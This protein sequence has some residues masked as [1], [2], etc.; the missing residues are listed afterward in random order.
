MRVRVHGLPA[1]AA[2]LCTVTA[3]VLTVLVFVAA[4]VLA[5]APGPVLQIHSFATPTSFMVADNT[6]CL[7]FKQIGLTERE[8][9]AYEVTVTNVGSQPTD[10]STVA[11]TDVLPAGVTVQRVWFD[12]SGLPREYGPEGTNL[13][14]FGLCPSTSSPVRCELPTG[15]FGLP[16]VAPDDTLRMFVYVTVEP[17]A[18]ASLTNTASVSGGGAGEAS[19]KV[20][21]SN[22]TTTPSFGI[23]A[24]ESPI[25]GLDGTPATQ[26]GAH[27]YEFAQRIDLNNVSRITP[28]SVYP[29]FTSIHDVRDVAVDLPVGFAGSALATPT[30]TLAQ[31][32]GPGGCPLDT[33][34]GHIETEG[35]EA[36]SKV[37]SPLFNMAPEHGVA[38][39]F[40]YVDLLKVT[41]VLYTS[42]VPT[43]GGYVL[44]ATSPE[45]PQVTLR[46]ILVTLYGNPAVKQ[47]E[48][49]RREGKTAS[50]I[51]PV[52]QFTNPT[53][54]SGEPLTTAIH[55]DSWQQPGHFNAD[56]TPDFTDP[57]WVGATSQAPPV[58]GCDLLQFQGSLTARPETTQA[59]TPSGL[60]V[61]LRVPQ[62]ENPETL[63]TPPLR[64][65]VVTLPAGLAVNPSAA[66]GLQTCSLA[67]IGMS[68]SGAPNASQPSCPDAS[69]IAS[70]EV[71]TPALAGVLQGSVYLAAQ[72][73]NPF[74]TLLAGYIV[75]DDPTTGV[76]LKLSGRIDPDPV[77]GQLVATF[78]ESPQFP[79]S[80]L[81]LH[82]F[83]GPRAPLTTPQGCGTYTT[84]SVL[85]PWSAPDSGPPATSADS[86]QVNS[87]CGG[88]FNPTFN[89]GTTNNQAGGFSPF[90]ATFTRNDQDQNLSGVS[91][92]MPQGL[93]GIIKGVEQCPEPQANQGT[94]G[95][96]SLIGHTTVAAGTGPNPFWVQGGQV[97]LTGP[98]KGAPFGLS[99][100][101][102]AVAGPFNLG[103]VVV[104]AAINVDPH[105][106]Q[107]TVTSDPLPTI[108]QGIPLDVRTVNVTI[109]RAG[110]TFNP[111]NC[112]PLSVGGALTSTQGATANVSS[113]FQAANCQGLPFKPSFTVST[114]ANTSKKNGASLDVKVGSTPGQANIGKVAVTL[115]KALP[116]RLTTIQ[117][118]CPEATFNANPASCPAGSNIGIA[119]AHTPVLTAPVVGPA[120]LVS[121]GGAAFPDLVLILQGEGVKLE[122]MGSINIKKQVTSSAFN[123]IPDAP[124]S[125]FELKLPEGPHS[126]LAAVLPAKAKG[127][128]C[129]TS[130]VMP[131][132]LTGQ[133]GAVIKQNT[134]IA[135]TGCT[136]TKKKPHKAKKGKKRKG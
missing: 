51:T 101:V 108:L 2:G 55:I 75:V 64:K 19:T 66:D 125:S 73:E 9:D 34:V 29:G 63:A 61:E 31:L 59:A 37:N 27:P 93:L 53:G 38:A 7:S 21:N 97:F 48:L 102:P 74:H 40:G 12:W 111:T 16:P 109:D 135:V 85:T 44:R 124:I 106:A 58:T 114:Q 41:H 76:L 122:L 71:E 128:L 67:Q 105:T 83:S 95:A 65:A 98:Y 133:N 45:I 25:T 54:C 113:R 50:S 119:T 56:G 52:A 57:N 116:S 22:G 87:G 129:G 90:T 121:H 117:Q 8:C 49:A 86:F 92:K 127:S 96:N 107:I 80:D 15:E 94:C 118:A 84:S 11:I 103:N 91:V 115:P 130:L 126:G 32:S 26:A 110:F 1:V 10:G 35:A 4:P 123:A 3:V 134:K 5:A 89:A 81:K 100:V 70:V 132:T 24:F 69:K 131:T 88:G 77:T 68:T 79:F 13:A 23:S 30:C 33:T 17:G 28:E 39:E 6:N 14:E 43:A 104:R 62:S 42:V 99:V 36:T 72:N 120:Y 20:Q 136:K 60:N 78:D 47:E 82:F 18:A 46:D 112:E